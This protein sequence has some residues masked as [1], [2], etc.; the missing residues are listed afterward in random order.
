M[1]VLSD[2]LQYESLAHVLAGQPLENDRNRW[3]LH[4]R[5]KGRSEAFVRTWYEAWDQTAERHPAAAQADLY[6]EALHATYCD[7]LARAEASSAAAS[8][9]SAY[10]RAASAVVAAVPEECFD[11]YRN[12]CPTF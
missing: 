3:V 12:I 4:H 8:L 7:S 6:R 5:A 11:H 10:Q 9:A 1:T 2:G